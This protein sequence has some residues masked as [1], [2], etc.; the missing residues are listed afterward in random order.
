MT[1]NE[2]LK[3]ITKDNKAVEYN[4]DIT[5]Q[6]YIAIDNSLEGNIRRTLAHGKAYEILKI[7][8]IENIV[9]RL[10]SFSIVEIRR[11]PK[12]DLP[13]YDCPYLLLVA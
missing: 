11:I 10:Q 9:L 4:Q 8:N 5:I 1:V 2:F 13:A 7:D 3:I 12:N 6:T